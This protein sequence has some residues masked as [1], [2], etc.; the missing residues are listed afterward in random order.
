M[1]MFTRSSRC[2][3]G[4]CRGRLCLLGER[5]RWLFTELLPFESDGRMVRVGP[6]TPDD[7][8]FVRAC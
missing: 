7:F 4:R 1:R 5:I 8:R 6:Q 2:H 3:C